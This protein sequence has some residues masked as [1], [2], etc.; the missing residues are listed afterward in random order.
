M[1]HIL[2]RNC[3]LKQAIEGRIHLTGRRG[4]RCK[5]LL[6]DLQ[7]M[8]G[9]QQLKEEAPNLT[10]WINRFGRV[11]G[12]IVRHYGMQLHFPDIQRHTSTNLISCSCVLL[13][14]FPN[15]SFRKFQFTGIGECSVFL[16]SPTIPAFLLATNK[17][18]I[19]GRSER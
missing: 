8:R 10:V 2:C 1:G 15:S 9:Y 11:Y 7:E 14:P 5:Q 12:T 3:L 16:A 18:S 13:L 17:A 6:D 19:S 4:R